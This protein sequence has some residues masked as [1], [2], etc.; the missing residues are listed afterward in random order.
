MTTIE[1]ST[2]VTHFEPAASCV[3]DVYHVFADHDSCYDPD[4]PPA[5]CLYYHLSPLTSR[6]DC[7]LKG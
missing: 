7:F 2:T 1:M 5:S 4:D 3:T 6:S